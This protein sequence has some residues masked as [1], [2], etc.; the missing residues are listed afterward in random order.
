MVSPPWTVTFDKAGNLYGGAGSNASQTCGGSSCGEVYKLTPPSK[1]Q[2]TWTQNVLYNFTG[3]ADGGSP[4]A[5]GSLV[6]DDAGNVYGTTGYG[7]ENYG[8]NG[9]GVVFKLTPNPVATTTTITKNTPNPSKTG[10]VVTVSFTVTQTAKANSL[11][12]AR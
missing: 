3:G 12:T 10:Q 2:T 11:P 1:G 7:G 4:D 8:T 6:I 9:F 5:L